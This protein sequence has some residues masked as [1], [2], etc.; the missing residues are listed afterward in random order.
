MMMFVLGIQHHLTNR[1]G[2]R[3][4]IAP[5]TWVVNPD[6]K[7]SGV[8]MVIEATNLVLSLAKNRGLA[9]E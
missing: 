9:S 3:W 5:Q 4:L 1:I 7:P 8:K 2:E 6:R